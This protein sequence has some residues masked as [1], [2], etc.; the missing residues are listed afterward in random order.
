MRYWLLASALPDPEVQVAVH[1]PRGREEAHADLGYS[2]WR[3]SLEYEGRQHAQLEQFGR[4]VERYTLFAA[5]G[6]LVLRF[7]HRHI[8]GPSTLVDRARRA[9]LSRG[10]QPGLS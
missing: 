4:D 5:S 9:L 7:A 1:D 10:W 8:G 3:V 6:W 2:R